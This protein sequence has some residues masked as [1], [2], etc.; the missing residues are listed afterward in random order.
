[1]E[2]KSLAQ[3][4]TDRG[5]PA[6]E[7]TQLSQLGD[8]AREAGAAI[9]EAAQDAT[10]R[11]AALASDLAGDAREQAIS[12]AE[13]GKDQ[14]GARLKDIAEAAHR[15]GER[16][17]GEQDWLAKLVEQGADELGSLAEFV[18]LSDL[19]GLIG[20]LEDLAR[21]QPVLFVGAAMAAGFAGAR[22]GKMAIAGASRSDLSNPKEMGNGSK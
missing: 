14:I 18:P 21:K 12:A 11:G 2:N 17:E 8:R 10:T 3:Q 19:R 1:M 7:A 13:E 20:K 22:L 15:S 16:L 5:E 9:T 4:P 6:G